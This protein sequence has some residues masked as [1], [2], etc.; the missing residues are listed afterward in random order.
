MI[1]EQQ[2][3]NLKKTV[4]DYATRVTLPD[5]TKESGRTY[6]TPE[7]Q[8]YPS[9]TTVLGATSDK[10]F[11]IEWKKRIGEDAAKEI[12]QKAA[13]RG[14][15]MHKLLE[16][17]FGGIEVSKDVPGYSYYKQ[18][19]IY[20]QKITPI[21]MEVPLYSDK[22][23]IAGRTDVIGVY[24]KELSIIDYKTSRK[25]KK[26]EWI[27]DYFLQSTIYA[28]MATER[29]E[30]LPKKIVIL[31]ATEEGMPQEFKRDTKDFVAEAY[32]RVQDYW[33][34]R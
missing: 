28:M 22:M 25:T 13:T 34:T 12:T 18:L 21:G 27:N 9:V 1:N 33:R 16:D 3:Q 32:G 4:S 31:I 7:G 15:S 10:S 30:I 17:H 20:W 5:E 11:L 2:L 23:R 29:L 19:K 6:V 24:D 26:A 8:K 14:T